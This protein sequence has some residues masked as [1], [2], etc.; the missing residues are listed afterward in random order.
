[1]DSWMA[2]GVPEGLLV[3]AAAHARFLIRPEPMPAYWSKL[4]TSKL[5]DAKKNFMHTAGAHDAGDITD[6]AN[7]ALLKDFIGKRRISLV[8]ADLAD[9]GGDEDRQYAILAHEFLSGLTLLDTKATANSKGS[10]FVRCQDFYKESTCQLVYLVS[11]LF[12]SF[13]LI[14]LV[15]SRPATN[16]RY[17]VFQHMKPHT[18]AVSTVIRALTEHVA[19]GKLPPD[20]SNAA[21]VKETQGL[22]DFRKYITDINNTHAAVQKTA[23]QSIIDC[24]G[25][26]STSV[27][28]VDVRAVFQYWCVSVVGDS[29]ST[30]AAA[31]AAT[32]TT[33]TSTTANVPV[34]E[35]QVSSKKYSD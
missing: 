35:P 23:L 18:P 30:A 32:T 34:L 12:E 13:A 24:A 20:A 22:R 33:T 5:V 15:S 19:S 16:E 3:Q 10:M 8:L 28:M 31:A 6:P 26:K 7:L 1:M 29:A 9:G 25:G 4:Q 17:M 11:L 21:L 27:E 14:K 2:L